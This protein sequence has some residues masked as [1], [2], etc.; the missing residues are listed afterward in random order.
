MSDFVAEGKYSG[1]DWHSRILMKPV[2]SGSCLI[3][4]WDKL[5][6][7]SSYSGWSDFAEEA[8]EIAIEETEEISKPYSVHG[9]VA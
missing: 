5:K 7:P 4:A 2:D 3:L 9:V 8:R 1:S 6:L